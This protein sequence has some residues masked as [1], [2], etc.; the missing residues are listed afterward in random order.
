VEAPDSRHRRLRIKELGLARMSFARWTLV[1]LALAA[2]GWLLIVGSA[3]FG[4]SATGGFLAAYAG[5]TSLSSLSVAGQAAIFSGFAI[6][7]LAALTRGVAALESLAQE[8]AA[9]RQNPQSLPAAESRPAPQPTPSLQIGTPAKT[10][11]TAA[12]STTP[13]KNPEIVSRGEISGREYVVFSDGT[14]GVET[15]LG[16]RRFRSLGDAREFIGA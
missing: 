2:V 6:A 16:R 4:A 14:V 13:Q 5:Q 10:A 12:A 15:L 8:L 3:I 1:G 11:T 9:A 7:I